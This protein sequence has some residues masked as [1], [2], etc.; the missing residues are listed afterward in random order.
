M[1]QI[2]EHIRLAFNAAVVA[3]NSTAESGSEGIAETHGTEDIYWVTRAAWMEGFM[4]SKEIM[5]A[6]LWRFDSSL[7]RFSS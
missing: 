7:L 5:M 2:L 4:A 3:I 6:L 1:K